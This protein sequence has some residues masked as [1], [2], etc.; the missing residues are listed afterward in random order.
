MTIK[1][2]AENLGI[3]C[4][5]VSRCLN[6]DPKVSE[7][8]RQ[9][10][11]AEAQRIGFVFNVNARSLITRKTQRIGLVY[12]NCF[13]SK[14]FRWFFNEIQT[15]ATLE[16][17][18]HNYDY[19]IQP[20]NNYMGLS[21]IGR[22]VSGKMVDGLAIFSRDISEVDVRLLQE[23][24]IPHVYVYY[25]PVESVFE[26]NFF[27]SSN[28]TGGYLATKYLIEQ[29][30]RRILT[31]RSNDPVQKMYEMRTQGY[32]LAMS[33]AGLEP[34]VLE[35]PMGFDTC[36]DGVRE[37]LD[38][39]AENFTAVFCQQSNPALSLIQEMEKRGIRVPDDIS[40]IGYDDIDLIRYMEIPLD[41]VLDSKS[42]VISSAIDSLV[43]QIEDT[44]DTASRRYEPTL[45][46][47]GS[48]K[49]HSGD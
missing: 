31:I 20:N 8:T 35:L 32:I 1:N 18:K 4:S 25:P 21:N 45:L 34:H 15:Y 44:E 13:N 48:V 40:V 33:E 47:R 46:H 19:L 27:Y 9:R 42:T 6:N 17:E 3:S 43:A 7:K 16:I 23:Q 28:K 10:V 39:M 41:V 38:Y 49:P 11:I 5:T 2:I 30:H 12:S 14:D 22:M 36:K 37:N 26:G 29:G 24:K